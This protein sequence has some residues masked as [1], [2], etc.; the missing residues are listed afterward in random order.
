MAAVE[1][2]LAEVDQE[3]YGGPEWVPF[4]ELGLDDIPYEQ[5]DTWDKQLFPS[6]ASLVVGSEL[7]RVTA[8]GVTGTVWLARQIAGIPT[9]P[10]A[11]FRIKYRLVRRREV[12]PEGADVDPP[13]SSPARSK[14]KASVK[15]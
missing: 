9:P 15:D 4:D 5:I 12:T 10:F 1:F 14:G 3:K 11:E 8:L 13:V 7:N 6:S 2:K